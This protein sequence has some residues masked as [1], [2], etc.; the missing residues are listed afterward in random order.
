[1]WGFIWKTV[2][3]LTLS[4][5]VAGVAYW[6]KDALT[7]KKD[8]IVK[9][10]N[11]GGPVKAVVEV[12]KDAVDGVTSTITGAADTIDTAKEVLDDPIGYANK[13]AREAFERTSNPDNK[14]HKNESGSMFSAIGK[15]LQGDFTGAA[16]AFAGEDGFGFGDGAKLGGVAAVIF[17]ISKLF[18]GGKDGNEK[19]GG[20]S[21]IN[22]TTITIGLAALAFMNRGL[23]MDKVNEFTGGDRENDNNNSFNTPDFDMS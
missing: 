17:G 15:L 12:G 23:I 4:S 5:G 18:G 14:D 22:S 16:S 21:L 1:M 20:F 3:G 6:N 19:D 13:T 2:A 11:E 10:F 7:D 9:D 8:D